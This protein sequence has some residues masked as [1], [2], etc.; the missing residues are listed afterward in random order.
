MSTDVSVQPKRLSIDLL[1]VEEDEQ[2][3]LYR[4]SSCQEFQDYQVV[5]VS[6]TGSDSC[7]YKSIMV[8]CSPLIIPL[9]ML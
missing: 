8:S 5:R 4:S 1:K 7:N 6:M 9:I 3:S 2:P